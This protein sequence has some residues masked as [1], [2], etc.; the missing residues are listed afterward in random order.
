MDQIQYSISILIKTRK[1]ACVEGVQ[2][3][4]V[5][6]PELMDVDPIAHIRN[7]PWYDLDA[8]FYGEAY[9]HSLDHEPN[10]GGQQGYTVSDDPND[11][12]F[13]MIAPLFYTIG[14]AFLLMALR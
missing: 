6:L 4:H 5:P 10:S 3:T 8:F 7:A 14:T 9:H 13:D 11:S 1:L 2:D 12:R